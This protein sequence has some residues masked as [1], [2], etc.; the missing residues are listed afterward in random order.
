MLDPLKKKV[1]GQFYYTDKDPGILRGSDTELI[2][3]PGS[4]ADS[5]FLEGRIRIR[6]SS[7]IECGFGFS[8]GSDLDSVFPRGSDPDLVFPPGSNADLVFLEGRIR[9]WFS[10]KVGSGFGFPRGSDPGQYRPDSQPWFKQDTEPLV[11]CQFN[12]TFPIER[13]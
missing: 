3:P 2:F 4:N 6:F 8:R 9:I 10:S 1:K 5:V 7:R 13:S 12:E 11:Q